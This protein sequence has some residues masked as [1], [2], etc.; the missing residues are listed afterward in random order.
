MEPLTINRIQYRWPTRPVVVICAD[1]C[2]PEYLERGFRDGILPHLAKLSCAGVQATAHSAMPS[3]TNPNNISIV[4][5][6]PPSSHGISGN[7]FYDV[8]SETEVMMDDPRLLRSETILSAFASRGARV[9]AITAKD[10]LCKLLSAG[11]CN[12]DFVCFSAECANACTL[13]DHGVEGI[14][15][16]VGRAQPEVYSGD[17]SLFVLDA[18]IRLLQRQ[19]FHLLYLS[20]SDYIQHKYAPGSAESNQFYSQL[21]AR[22]GTLASLDIVLG[23]VADHGMSDK[24]HNDGTPQVIYLLDEL[25]REFGVDQTKVILPI[26][27]P[28]VVHHGALGG[29]ARVYCDHLPIRQVVTFIQQITGIHQVL[30][31]EEACQRFSLPSDR[32]ADLVVVSDK[33]YAIGTQ[34]T[35]HD[36][37]ALQ[38]HRLR[39]HGG[40][41]EQRVP[42]LISHPLTKSYTNRIS[43]TPLNNYDIF[44]FAINGT[45][46]N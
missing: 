12:P 18:G 8:E 1:G 4:T 25:Q 37:R 33:H 32:E 44:D 42:F 38:P 22:I 46:G 2:D 45:I 26:T 30:T 36:L 35:Q 19:R 9:G 39:S 11:R 15:E 13:H 31:R 5:G 6:V 43:Q 29:F 23:I 7:Y 21:D 16:M 3:F 28:Y 34:R 40:L 41:S 24:S 17:L 27:D 14:A 20:L 10:K